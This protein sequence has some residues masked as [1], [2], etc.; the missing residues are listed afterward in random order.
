MFNVL[1]GT[2]GTGKTSLLNS[3]RGR[4]DN[5]ITDGFSRPVMKAFKQHSDIY[6][7]WLEQ[8]TINELTLW[9]WKNYLNQNV[10]STRSLIDV[11]AYNAYYH[12]S[13]DS[14]FYDEFRKDK[15]RVRFFYIPIEFNLISDGFR[16]EDKEDQTKIDILL[17][18]F[19]KQ[20]NI[21]FVTITGTVEARAE[22]IMQYL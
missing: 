7:S 20:E 10:I 14:R 8:Q 21:D 4:T 18:D 5:Y 3:L 6:D 2:H 12:G 19:L 17:Y 13:I 15:H 22:Q 11:I 9:G 16:F 1:V